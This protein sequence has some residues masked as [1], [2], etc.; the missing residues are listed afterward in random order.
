MNRAPALLLALAM[1]LPAPALARGFGAP[2]TLDWDRPEP[3]RTEPPRDQHTEDVDFDSLSLDEKRKIQ[4]SLEVRRKMV[5]VHTVLAFVASGMIVATEVVGVINSSFLEEPPDGF[6]RTDLEPSL[7]VHRALATGAMISYWGSG[8]V[9]WAMPPALRFN[10]QGQPQTKK[11][12]SGE[13]HAI[14]SIIHGIA[15]GTVLVTG[16]LQANVI[17]ASD[18]WGA[19]ESTHAI[20][21][22]TAA[23]TVI[24]AAIVIG[25]L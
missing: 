9:A 3:P 20:A 15:M 10:Q 19:V 25:T 18:A 13:L 7:A 8:A 17:P 24:A 22:F 6:K 1:L 2:P 23:G 5:D 14:L 12:D 16:I 11:V 4:K 21:G